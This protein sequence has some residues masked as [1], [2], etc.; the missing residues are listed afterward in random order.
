LY[1]LTVLKNDYM[2]LILVTTSLVTVAA[3]IV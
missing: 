2:T 3:I 1:L